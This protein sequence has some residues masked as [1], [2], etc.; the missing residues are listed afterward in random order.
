MTPQQRGFVDVF[1]KTYP[2]EYGTL[3]IRFSHSY[4]CL[5]NTTNKNGKGKGKHDKWVAQ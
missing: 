5:K 3:N 1:S 2:W 4:L